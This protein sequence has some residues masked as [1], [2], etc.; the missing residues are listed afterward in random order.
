MT[1]VKGTLYDSTY[2][3]WVKIGDNYLL[4]QK[5]FHSK[6]ELGTPKESFA[7][8]QWVELTKMHYKDCL[9]VLDVET[10]EA[11]QLT[12]EEFKELVDK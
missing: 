4:V 12:K 11:V 6:E 1:K 5:T 3:S 2:S 10:G 9:G 7:F 8:E